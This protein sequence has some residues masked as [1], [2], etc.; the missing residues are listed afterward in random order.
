MTLTHTHI[1]THTHT[2]AGWFDLGGMLDGEKLKLCTGMSLLFPP[3]QATV[4]STPPQSSLTGAQRAALTATFLLLYI[5]ILRQPTLYCTKWYLIPREDRLW[6]AHSLHSSDTGFIVVRQQLPLLPPSY[7]RQEHH[8]FNRS[9]VLKMDVSSYVLFLCGNITE[10]K[11]LKLSNQMPPVCHTGFCY[12]II[13][14][15]ICYI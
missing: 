5:L 8:I 12:K 7:M 10:A 14:L 9:H 3:V 6:Q 1:H 11:V 15:I 2:D 13:C 4:H